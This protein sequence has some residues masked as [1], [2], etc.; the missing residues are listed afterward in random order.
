MYQST[1][2]DRMNTKALLPTR[3]HPKF[4]TALYPGENLERAVREVTPLFEAMLEEV[5]AP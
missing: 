4:M 1:K 3:L 2:E 5:V